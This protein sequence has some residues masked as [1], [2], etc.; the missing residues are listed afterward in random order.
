MCIHYLGNLPRLVL[1]FCWRENIKDNKKNTAFLLVS[2]KDSYTEKFLVLFPCIYVLQPKLIHFYQTSSLFP[3]PLLIVASA[4][5][6]LFYFLLYSEH[7]N[8]I[9]I[10]VFLLFPYSSC[11][12]F[13]L[14]CDPCPIILRICFRSIIHIWGRTCGFWP[15]FN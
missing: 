4:S 12:W 2:D 5:L 8:R 9:Q 1:W 11:A 15:N 7:I 13:P 6:R 14:V 3:G 10:F